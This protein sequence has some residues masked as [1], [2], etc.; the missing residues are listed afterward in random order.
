MINLEINHLMM[1]FLR[2]NWTSYLLYQQFLWSQKFTRINHNLEDQK[3]ISYDMLAFAPPVHTFSL[4]WHLTQRVFFNLI[5][6]FFKNFILASRL[7][8][9]Q[10]QRS[11]SSPFTPIVPGSRIYWMYTWN[12][13]TKEEIVVLSH[14]AG[15]NYKQ[16]L[17]ALG[18]AWVDFFV[19]WISLTVA[20]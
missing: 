17:K 2:Q 6:W 18:K 12:S 20:V 7:R 16:I 9:L 15:C 1:T 13:E 19:W 3:V 4:W 11:H 14:D 8:T 5:F 10:L